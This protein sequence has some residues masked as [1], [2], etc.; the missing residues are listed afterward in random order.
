MEGYQQ[1]IAP[2]LITG[3]V[4]EE[5]GKERVRSFDSVDD[6]TES[7]KNDLWHLRL[8]FGYAISSSH[9]SLDEAY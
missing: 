7:S 9:S 3:V 8:D 6:V 1:L 4:I 2:S 5:V